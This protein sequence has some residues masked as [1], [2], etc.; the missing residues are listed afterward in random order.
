[1]ATTAELELGIDVAALYAAHAGRLQQFVR[2][3]VRAPEPV[4]EDA[5]SFAWSRLVLHRGRVRSETASAWLGKTAI[6][7]ALKLT[8]RERRDVSLDELAERA[9]DGGRALY[10]AT[11]SLEEV[12]GR[13]AR[14]ATVGSLSERQQRLVWLQAF[15]FSY[16]EMAEQ[17]GD[18]TRTVERQMLRAK[19][20]LAEA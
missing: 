11:P 17:T 5:C 4:I 18:T 6:R 1:M 13:R 14:L 20:K 16:A 7:E 8:R 2:A 19:R 15:G 3:S 10:P 9:R 12:V